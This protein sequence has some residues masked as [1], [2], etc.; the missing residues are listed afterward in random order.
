MKIRD[1]RITFL[2]SAEGTTIELH[3]ADA[4]ITFAVIKLT[5]AQLSKALSRLAYTECEV[6]VRSLELVGT[7]MENKKHEFPLT[8]KCGDYGQQKEEAVLEAIRTCP[9]G[10]APD[11]SFNSR[12]STFSKDGKYYGQTTIR[13]WVPQEEKK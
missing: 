12:D 9:E 5:P 6:E 11:L 4:S 1:A 7:R 3:D 2:V 13:R 8:P 10:W